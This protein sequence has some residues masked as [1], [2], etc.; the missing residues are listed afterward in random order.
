M[1]EGNTTHLSINH[2]GNHHNLIGLCVWELQW[3]FGGLYVVSQNNRVLKRT[4]NN[5]LL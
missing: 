3:Q 1:C 5:V 2:V 4:R